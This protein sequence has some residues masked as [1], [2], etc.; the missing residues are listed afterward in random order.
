MLKVTQQ[1]SGR[2]E[3]RMKAT[4]G[5]GCFHCLT[6]PVILLVATLIKG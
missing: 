5:Q 1:F 3:P 4:Q 2:A 6:L